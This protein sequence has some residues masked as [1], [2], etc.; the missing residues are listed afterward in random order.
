MQH[1]AR[2]VRIR[3]YFNKDNGTYTLS[4]IWKTNFQFFQNIFVSFIFLNPWFFVLLCDAIGAQVPIH[5]CMHKQNCNS[6]QQSWKF[7]VCVLRCQI[8]FTN[9]KGFSMPNFLN[10]F[11]SARVETVA[12]IYHVK[13]ICHLILF[14]ALK[15][16]IKDTIN[17][18][19]KLN[20]LLSLNGILAFIGN[21]QNFAIK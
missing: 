12:N 5:Y 8:F 6:G 15:T 20:K 13:L 10:S 11:N 4:N 16:K 19:K 9:Q 1:S 14:I 7:F 21:L 18:R 2:K 17:K 3:Y